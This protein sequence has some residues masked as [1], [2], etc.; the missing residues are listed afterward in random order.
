MPGDAGALEAGALLY[1]T[2]GGAMASLQSDTVVSLHGLTTLSWH[3]VLTTCT[4]WSLISA[5]PERG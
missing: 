3:V 4:T 2:H 1:R 5:G